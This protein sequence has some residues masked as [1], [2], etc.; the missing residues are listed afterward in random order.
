MPHR[1]PGLGRTAVAA[2][3]ALFLVHA[4]AMRF[5][6]DDAFISFRYA[7]N[8]IRHGEL[9][10]NPGERVEGYSNFLWTMLMAAVLATGLDPVPSSQVL[11]IL[12]GLAT[13]GVVARFAARCGGAASGWNATAAWMLAGSSSFAAW[14][15]GGLETSLFVLV[16]TLAWTR[17]ILE[18][19][20]CRRPWSGVWFGVC[21]LVRPEGALAFALA[22]MH[23]AV[24]GAAAGRWRP[25]RA[26]LW[27]A[28]GFLVFFGPHLAWRWLYYGWPL[29]NTYYVK[30]SGVALWQPGGRYVASWLVGHAA[31][32]AAALPW[33]AAAARRRMHGRL[34]L[35]VALQLAGFAVHVAHA[36]GD[37]MAMHRFLVHL[38]PALAVVAALGL[39]ALPWPPALCGR[40]RAVVAAAAIAVAVVVVVRADRSTLRVA[41]RDGID[42]IGMLRQYAAQWTAIGRWLAQREPATTRIA[43]SAAGAIPYYSRLYTLDVLGLSDAW[44]AHAMP[45]ER[46]Q[47]GHAKRAPEHYILSKGIDLLILHPTVLPRRIDRPANEVEYFAARGFVWEMTQVPGLSP[48]WWG[49]WRRVR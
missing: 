5:V 44:I 20:S 15:T 48:P 3:L 2:A 24:L 28:G 31:W 36:G 27:W 11:G 13:L 10:F 4:V 46:G 39:E 35:M 16:F 30:A 7:D 8:L 33:M 38:L 32:I 29:P 25:S 18:G 37:F 9:V 42:S 40:R 14:S 49:A 22:A 23:R 45:Q 6:C 34:G 26:D 41:H 43:T 19:E 47:A 1:R 12:A 21:A 17:C